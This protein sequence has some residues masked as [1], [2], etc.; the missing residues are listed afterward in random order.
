MAI[1]NKY[2]SQSF[3]ELVGQDHVT[4]TLLHAAQMKKMSHAYEFCGPRGTGKTST[5][6]LLAKAINCLQPRENG[7]PCNE[8]RNCQSIQSKR[9]TDVIEVD[10]ASNNGVDHIRAILENLHYPPQEGQ[11]KIIILDEVHMLST[12]AFNALLKS[13]EEPPKHVIFILCTTEPHKVL[14]TI[15][16]RCQRYEFKRISP[17]AMVKRMAY[18]CEQESVPFEDG[19]LKAIAQIAQGGMRDALSLLEQVISYKDGTLTAD[20]V[21][22]VV[23]KVSLSFIAKMIYLIQKRDIVNVLKMVDDAYEEGKEPEYFVEDLITYY[24][25]IMVYQTTEDFSLLN[26]AVVNNEFTTLVNSLPASS[27]QT[28]IMHLNECKGMMKWSNQAKIS[29]D[30]TL[31]KMMGNGH[32][33]SNPV[34][35]TSNV[36]ITEMQQEIRKLQEVVQQLL[37][38]KGQDS[39]T[40]ITPVPPKEHQV[41][42]K[43]FVLNVVLKEAT[44]DCLAVMKEKWESIINFL[45]NE[46]LYWLFSVAKITVCSPRH[47]VLAFESDKNFEYASSKDTLQVLRES[48]QQVIRHNIEPIVLLEQDWIDV[49]QK[50]VNALKAQK[51]GA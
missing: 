32:D 8:C 5:A 19:A 16:S 31:I 35:G 39:I 11:Y 33:E 30:T 20:D 3:D 21:S 41:S 50:Y 18:I 23:G 15:H 1:Y 42:Q 36:I 10:A 44:K 51:A 40:T 13:L 24:R 34:V 4:T 9:S 43:D 28:Y 29:L 25:D 26:M 45:N 48:I 14:D 6:Y 22:S 12:G 7:E 2:R 17:G 37:N 47:V 49:K 27:I 46:E 38:G